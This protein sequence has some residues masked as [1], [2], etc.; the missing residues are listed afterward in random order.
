L[1]FN[2]DT[3]HAEVELSGAI[4]DP[5]G[6]TFIPA[7]LNKI[8]KVAKK[9]GA[10]V[11]TISPMLRYMEP[12]DRRGFANAGFDFADDRQKVVNAF[13]EFLFDKL[14]KHLTSKERSNIMSFYDIFY[15]ADKWTG[16]I[17]DEFL[18]E[19]GLVGKKVL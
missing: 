9:H 19:Y 1:T 3:V 2:G 6:E 15:F 13:D 10:K 18:Q 5:N 11:M 17:G 4:D 7:A 12:E 8:A 14:D 16:D